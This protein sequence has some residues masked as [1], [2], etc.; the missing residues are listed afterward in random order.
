MQA[1]TDRAAR[2]QTLTLPVMGMHCAAC[3]EPS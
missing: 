1:K 3:V 2:S